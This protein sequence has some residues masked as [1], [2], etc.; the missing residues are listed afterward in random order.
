MARFRGMTD[1]Y[2]NFKAS[3]AGLIRGMYKGIEWRFAR[4]IVGGFI[5]NL[6]KDFLGPKMY[7]EQTK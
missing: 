6:S 4:M 3:E 1:I 2:K 5:I 7:P